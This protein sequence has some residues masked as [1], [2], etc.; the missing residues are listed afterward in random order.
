MNAALVYALQAAFDAAPGETCWWQRD[1]E[2]V[3]VTRY[4]LGYV[5]VF[6]QYEGDGWQQTGWESVL[7]AEDALRRLRR[8][9]CAFVLDELTFLQ[10]VA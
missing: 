9:P 5:L 2:G 1:G 8:S 10:K 3:R 4:L 7:T 6:Q